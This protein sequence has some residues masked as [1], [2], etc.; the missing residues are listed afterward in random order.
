MPSACIANLCV[1][2]DIM[3]SKADVTVFKFI[4]VKPNKPSQ[5]KIII[6]S[7]LLEG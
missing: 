7:L 5:I 6:V 2:F 1:Q 4:L 3:V